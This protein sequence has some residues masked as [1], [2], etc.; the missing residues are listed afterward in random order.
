M[1]SGDTKVLLCTLWQR[2]SARG[3]E[4]LSGFV[5]KAR[6][7]AFRGEPT[8]DGTLTWNVY[9]QPSKEQSEAEGS[10]WGG[11]NRPMSSTESSKN[12][13]PGSAAGFSLGFQRWT[14]VG[15]RL[16]PPQNE[17]SASL[18]SLLGWR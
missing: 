5:G 1:S 10:S 12:G 17:P 14:P 7:I 8:A 2:T 11:T 3:N 13:L 15:R 6:I 18:C 4:Y 16:L 9:L